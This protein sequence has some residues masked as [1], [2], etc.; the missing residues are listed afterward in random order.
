MK[1]TRLF[2]GACALALAVGCGSKATDKPAPGA[3]GSSKAEVA[4]SGKA[5]AASGSATAKAPPALKKGALPAGFTLAV[6]TPK[7][8]D[9][10]GETGIHVSLVMS[11]TDDPM[12]AYIAKGLD[13]KF[14]L[15]FVAW[16]RDA[17]KWKGPVTIDSLE[18]NWGF[19]HQI[20]LA[21]DKS[22][23][24]LAVAYHKSGKELWLA[25]SDGGTTWKTEKLPALT[26]ESVTG[27]VSLAIAK[28]GTYVAMNDGNDVK[29]LSRFAA[30]GEFKVDK[31][32]LLGDTSGSKGL[33]VDV[34]TDADGKPG[35]LYALAPKDGYNTTIAFWRPS[36]AAAVKVTDSNNIQNDGY[37]LR[38]AFAGNKPR[39]AINLSRGGGEKSSTY[40]VSSE[41]GK[42]WAPPM[43]VSPDGGQAM[44]GELGFAVTENAAPRPEVDALVLPVT[45]GNGTG[46]KCGEP[47]LARMV[48]QKSFT[49]CSPDAD[50]SQAISGKYVSAAFDSKGKLY[51]A[52]ANYAGESKQPSGLLVWHE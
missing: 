41:D 42:E 22:S 51:L 43:N 37:F 6:P 27:G 25:Q 19:A 21:R 33:D 44:D 48:D 49:T 8:G 16:D 12:M 7:D 13:E 30:T 34:D 36:E 28:G 40:F 29:L 47:K 39:A 15:A 2:W 10:S 45:G 9:K 38:L 5:A 35:L 14:Y 1:T 18:D 3:S 24:S 46:T 17:G 52:I 26:A 32:P 11:A 20:E 50:A 31:A 23:G 4:P